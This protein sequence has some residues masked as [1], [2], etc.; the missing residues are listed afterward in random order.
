[1]FLSS[2]CASQ[3]ARQHSARSVAGPR[4]QGC[5]LQPGETG[6]RV[7]SSSWVCM[8]QVVTVHSGAPE[9]RSSVDWVYIE[10]TTIAYK[11]EP[12]LWADKAV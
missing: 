4:G 2:L 10:S 12:L 1:M 9:N 3:A 11:P 7:A 5:A 6:S 8:R